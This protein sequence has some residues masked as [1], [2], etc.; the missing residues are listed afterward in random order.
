MASEADSLLTSLRTNS[1]AYHESR[2]LKVS[3]PDDEA[4][5]ASRIAAKLPDRLS[6]YIDWPHSRSIDRCSLSAR[7][8]CRASA[9]SSCRV[10]PLKALREVRA[11]PSAERGPLDR[12]HGRRLRINSA[13]RARRCGVQPFAMSGFQ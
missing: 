8:T 5:F 1:L 2:F 13:C 4:V 11:L 7:F 6:S 10:P 9:R 12:S 3:L